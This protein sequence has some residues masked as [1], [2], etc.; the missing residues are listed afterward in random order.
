MRFL[1]VV[2]AR[3]DCTHGRAPAARQRQAMKQS[4]FGSAAL[5][6]AFVVASAAWVGCEGETPA[7][8]ATAPTQADG[9]DDLEP[10]DAATA[11]APALGEIGRAHV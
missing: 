8:D 3:Q 7:A 11:D 10:M 5:L 9:F 2:A 1:T 6:A 4:T